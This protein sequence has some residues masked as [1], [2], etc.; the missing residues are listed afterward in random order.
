MRSA[1]G[2]P[3]IIDILETAIIVVD[4]IGLGTRSVVATILYQTVINKKFTL[5]EIEK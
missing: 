2:N 1:A 4:Q 3:V 5:K